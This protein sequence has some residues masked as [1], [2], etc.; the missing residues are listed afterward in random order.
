MTDG[1]QRTG[2]MTADTAARVCA[3][4]YDYGLLIGGEERPA[5]SGKRFSVRTPWTGEV[6]ATFAEAGAADVAAAT[7]AAAN[8]LRS[9]PW[10]SLTPTKRGLLLSQLAQTLTA[11]AEDIAHLEV[12]QNGKL[13]REMLAQARSVPEWIRYF[14]GLADKIEGR[15]VPVDRS[16]TLAYTIEEPLGVIGIITPWNSPLLL[17]MMAVGPALAAGNTVVIKPSEVTPASIV[18]FARLAGSSGI[19]PG[20]VNVVTGGRSAG[21]ALAGDVRVA[22][23]C[24]TGGVKGGREIG[25]A[26]GERLAAATLEL[27]GKSANIVFADADLDA[28][29]AGIFAGI[30]AAGG[31]SCVA[32]SRVFVQDEIFDAFS[33]RLVG[34]AQRIRLGNP[35]ESN[36]DMGPVATRHQFD[37]IVSMVDGAKAGGAVI[38]CGGEPAR[39]DALPEALFYKPTIMTSVDPKSAIAQEEV[40]GPVLIVSRFENEDNVVREANATHYGL[41]A[42]V[43]TADLKRAHRMAKQLEA[44]TVWLNMYRVLG[45]NVPFGGVK[46]SGQGRINGMQAISQFLQTKSVWCELGD[47]IQDPFAL[48]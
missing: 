23:I 36:T 41:A 17:T 45:F 25:R 16:H 48:Q 44:G 18:E 43:W 5:A 30:F 1:P 32:G 29:E 24:F 15:V 26:T 13:L 46:D 34:R 2:R 20:V 4:R 8:A 9:G 28:A 33:K 42:G 21:E 35:M 40:F 37:K 27:G 12:L 39:V 31:Q 6:W 14:A 38:L 22:R 10:G 47:D 3:A 7:L 11:H 19:P